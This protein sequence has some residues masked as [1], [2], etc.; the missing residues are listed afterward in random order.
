MQGA[1]IEL[2]RESASVSNSFK[3]AQN[4]RENR[5][6]HCY[7]IVPALSICPASWLSKGACMDRYGLDGVGLTACELLGG[8]EIVG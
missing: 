7:C 4:Q 2:P 1:S 8:V 5:N 3:L 6:G